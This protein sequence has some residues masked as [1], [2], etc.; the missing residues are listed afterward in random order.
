MTANEVHGKIEGLKVVK[1]EARGRRAELD[2]QISELRQQTKP[3]EDLEEELDAH[4]SALC[5]A[6]RNQYSKAAI[7]Q[8]VAAGIKELDQENAEE[9]D[10]DNFDP[11]E[12]IRDYDEVARTLPVFCVSS[13]AYQKLS[14][15][16]KVSSSCRRGLVHPTTPYGDDA[17]DQT[18]R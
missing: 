3:I 1:K 8:D 11:E 10:P 7:Q 17:D 16:M 15:R 5:I 2:K 13:K 6:G 14:G 18:E 9:E 4:Q 12:D